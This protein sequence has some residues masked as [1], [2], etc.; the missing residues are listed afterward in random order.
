MGTSNYTFQLH[1]VGNAAGDTLNTASLRS[2]SVQLNGPGGVFQAALTGLRVVSPIY[3][4]SRTPRPAVL[5]PFEYVATYSVLAPGGSW[6]VGDNGQYVVSMLPN[7]V[8]DSLGDPV[9]WA[10]G[11]VAAK[12]SLSLAAQPIDL[13]SLTIIDNLGNTQ[14]LV[15]YDPGITHTPPPTVPDPVQ[16]PTTVWVPIGAS[17]IATATNLMNRINGDIN[18]FGAGQA[19]DP[20]VNIFASMGL[21]AVVT[22][23]CKT[24]GAA[25]N[26]VQVLG[27]VNGMTIVPFSGGKTDVTDVFAVVMDAWQFGTGG[28]TSGLG[29]QNGKNA[30]RTAVFQDVD[31]TVVT[32]KMTGPGYAQINWAPGIPGVTPDTYTLS[33]PYQETIFTYGATTLTLP[34]ATSGSTITLT[35]KKSRLAGGNATFDVSGI[36]S[37]MPIK[38]LNAKTTNLTGTLA[39]LAPVNLGGLDPDDGLTHQGAI[40]QIT[41]GNVA[42]SA[43]AIPEVTSQFSKLSLTA[44][45]LSNTSIDS[46]HPF[47]LI[48]ANAWLAGGGASSITTPFINK[49]TIKGNLEA[50]L[51]LTGADALGSMGMMT[52]TGWYR[53]QLLAEGNLGPITVGGLDSA[54]IIAIGGSTSSGFVFNFAAADAGTL[55]GTFTSQLTI[56]S[57][58]V[59]G[60]GGA[61]SYIN[62]DIA[63]FNMGKIVVANVRPINGGTE[64]GVV[65][66]SIAS[67]TR[68]FLRATQFRATNLLGTVPVVVDTVAPD[69]VCRLV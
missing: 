8:F 13:Q 64:F 33:V 52:V 7:M 57:L 15:F 56:A 17:T 49:L 39:L 3:R 54:N 10:G 9:V 1:F 65:A 20:F 55:G 19:H 34:T 46:V 25:G 35:T 11:S 62:S 66:H 5:P 50:N 26:A 63:A 23:T 36:S 67:Y 53:G 43:W 37:Y 29:L 4:T 41:L 69:Y 30:S 27:V 16:N 32:A 42:N 22:L 12:G 6:D 48:Q 24:V 28:T 21:G 60:M 58:T 18:D 2:Q 31:G 45:Q 14:T 59:K 51:T 40:S 61:D 44:G 47:S 38:A 68:T